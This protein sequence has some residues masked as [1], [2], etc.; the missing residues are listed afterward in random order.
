MER[1]GQHRVGQVGAVTLL[2]QGPVDGVEMRER[3]RHVDPQIGVVT[4][5]PGV[6]V[7]DRHVLQIHGGPAGQASQRLVADDGQEPR[8]R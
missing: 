8:A 6:H 2:D 3:A 4:R 1:L 7:D 5:P